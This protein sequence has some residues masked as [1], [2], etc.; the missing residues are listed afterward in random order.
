MRLGFCENPLVKKRVVWGKL[1]AAVV[2]G[3]AERSGVLVVRDERRAEV[4]VGDRAVEASILMEGGRAS[5]LVSVHGGFLGL[6]VEYT[7]P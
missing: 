1:S 7:F 2:A 4:D 3:A 6:T 5:D